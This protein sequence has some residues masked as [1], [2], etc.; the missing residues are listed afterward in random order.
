MNE[1]A[2]RI[3][4]RTLELI[5]IA[6]PSRDEQ[7]IADHVLAVLSEGGVEATDLG[8]CCVI[9]GATEAQSRPFVLLGGHFDT[10]PAQGNI[11][12]RI[13]GDSV[14]G[15]GAADMKGSLAVMIELALAGVGLS[16]DRAVDYGFLFFSR[17]ELP[18]SESS[19]TPLLASNP[20]LQSAELAVMMEPTA[21]V[22]QA[23]CLG[24]CGATWR[25]MGRSGH[26]ARPWLADNAIERLG[27]GI[28]A[29]TALE[30]IEHEFNGLV[31]REVISVTSV[32]GGVARNVI[33]G[34]ATAYLNYRYPPGISRADAEARLRSICEPF[35]TIEI[36]GNSPSG[37]V[38]LDG[39][40][41]QRLVALV[42]RPVE[43]KQAWTPVAEFDAA[44]IAALNYGPGTPAQAHTVDE[45]VDGSAL[46]ESFLTLEK[47]A[48]GPG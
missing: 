48:Q 44:G 21:N 43:P 27:E 17:E 45:S 13:E 16:G 26:S 12:G 19:L 6:S 24:N 8:D 20:G 14:V 4:A 18:A 33:P 37:S 22:V 46:A 5:D 30:P 28:A 41:A 15:L 23:G 40:Q 9:A 31:F 38:E 35:G 7:A 11:P 34:E 10:V 39:N 32:A 29:I 42:D 1:L 3:A 47:F 2:D 36:E 25:F